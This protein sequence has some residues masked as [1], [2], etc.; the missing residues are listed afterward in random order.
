MAPPMGLM[1]SEDAQPDRFM[2][3]AGAAF[4]GKTTAALSWPNPLVLDFDNKVPKKGTNTIPFHNDAFVDSIRPRANRTLPA[5]RRDAVH[6]WLKQNINRLSEYT[7]I[8][9]SLTMW[10]TAFHQQTFDVEEKWGVNGGLYFGA[11][12]S[13]FQTAFALLAASKARIIVNC[14]LMPIYVRD[15]KT[16]ADIA[17]GKNKPSVTGSMAERLPT[18]CTSIVYTYMKCDTLRGGKLT[19]W[20]VLRPC[21]AFDAR[22]IA[23]KIPDS[24]EIEVTGSA[25]EAF[26]KCF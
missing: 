5:N 13:Y 14:H 22:T 19:Y 20:W 18:Y 7:V 1:P 10:E 8:V 16:G 24:G 3:L 17:I 15:E 25:Y 11:K 4:S 6:D 12:L 26:R 9:D 21:L 2:L 23:T